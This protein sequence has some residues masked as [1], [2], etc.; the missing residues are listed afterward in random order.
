MQ[1]L[2][3]F[4]MFFPMEIV[5]EVFV[6][7]DDLNEKDRAVGATMPPYVK[8]IYE[9]PIKIYSKATHAIRGTDASGWIM[10]QVSNLQVDQYG[11]SDLIAILDADIVFHTHCIEKLMFRDNKPVMFCSQ[12]RDLAFDGARQLDPRMKSLKPW[13]CMENFPFV[14]W[15]SLFPSLRSWLEER[16]GKAFPDNL[17]SITNTT[18]RSA[19]GNFAWIGGY[20]HTY[21]HDDYF[22]AI[23]GNG[24]LSTCPE[25]RAAIHVYY[26]IPKYRTYS[27]MG[28][29]YFHTAAQA[30]QHGVCRQE[31]AC[32][33][34]TDACRNVLSKRSINFYYLSLEGD[35]EMM[36]GKYEK[37]RPQ[38][39][40][41]YD[42]RVS[43]LQACLTKRCAR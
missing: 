12:H 26:S 34:L 16:T 39:K 11:V 30:M 10:S 18:A 15:R 17:V 2:R 27:K 31:S 33:N 8:V 41:H 36:F 35:N 3:S 20:A 7:F 6:V 22:W 9:A 40:A 42:N 24:K 38:C 4:E 43:E 23:G 25:I 32:G 5:G 19:F 28:L 13:S 21:R 29:E 1:M 14:V 37:L